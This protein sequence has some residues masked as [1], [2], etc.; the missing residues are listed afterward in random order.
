MLLAVVAVS[1]LMARPAQ[2]LIQRLTP[3]ADVLDKTKLIFTVKVESIDADRP[4]IILTVDESLKGKAPFTKMAVALKGDAEA[5]KHKHTALL[6][7]RVAPKLPL[8]VFA[9]ENGKTYTTFAYTNGTWLQLTGTQTPDGVRW[10]FLHCE[11]Y[12]RKTFKGTTAELRQAVIDGLSGKKKPP[13]PDAK[14]EPGLGPRAEQEPPRRRSHLP[15]AAGPP[16]A[17]IPTVLVGG[18]L[19]LLAM[20][21]P[22]VF[23]GLMLVLRRWMAGLC[24]ISVN[25]T[26][27]LLHGYLATRFLQ[28]WWATPLALWLIMCVLNTVGLMWAWRRHAA[29]LAAPASSPVPSF[30]QPPGRVELISLGLLSL[31][32]LA[33]VVFGLPH[34][35][36]Q[37]DLWGKT[38]WMI[39]CGVWAAL[40]HALARCALAA[41][42]A[43]QPALPGEGVM[44]WTMLLAGLGFSATFV[45][46]APAEAA[47]DDGVPF[48]VVW[49]FRPPVEGS[50]VASS[51]A[52]GEDHL[53]VGIAQQLGFA[54]SGAVYCVERGTGKVVWSFNDDGAMKPVFSS[55]CLAG[56]RL[57]VGEGFHQDHSCKLYC[58]DAADGKKLWEHETTSHTE[59]APIVAEG[60]V[61]CGA[62]DDGLYCLEAATGKPLW[63]FEKLH[64][65]SPP[66]IVDGRLY[67]GS[68]VGDECRDKALFCLDAETG[69][70]HWRVPVDLPAPGEPVLED[71]RLYFSLGNGN[72]MQRADEM[73][74]PEK[75]AG[76]VICVDAGTGHRLWRY[77]VP[78]S[79]LVRPTVNAG[80]VL[81]VSRDQ[82]CYCVDG[83][84]GKLR[85]KADLDS[86]L[87][88]APVVVE[89]AGAAQLYLATSAGRVCRLDAATGKVH[90]EMDV[91]SDIKLPAM[92]YCSPV[93][94]TTHDGR[95]ERRRLYFGCGLNGLK[96]GILY[97]LE[98]RLEDE[99]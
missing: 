45:V 33:L 78:D 43:A 24:I 56:G 95:R 71:G 90:W 38:V 94:R 14:A 54:S 6:L 92:V 32:C 34:A 39:S 53:Y 37:L 1:L 51:P 4:A 36:A 63:H 35:L 21:F 30:A 96:S 40:L 22:A 72:L 79:V 80:N 12:L 88:A 3:L 70:Q 82:H 76:A 64:I 48:R 15:H 27:Y 62:G 61:Y 20:L 46:E 74:T 5:A 8:V 86:P 18:P 7:E 55:P 87:L 49:R 77:D 17:V 60:R 68:L 73:P 13:G 98:D 57:Y 10:R 26:L 41:R 58:L 69:K 31:G 97:C 16:L 83:R 52:I 85:W 65:D 2:A 67:G 59:A 66:L 75:P 44:L 89:G 47:A 84:N 50:W 91:E 11:P 42:G 93:V 81:F 99:Q 29:W 28:S 9:I 23:G 25:S 19:A